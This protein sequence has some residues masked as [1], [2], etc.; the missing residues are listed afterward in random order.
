MVRYWLPVLALYAFFLTACAGSST[1]AATPTV[2][3]ESQAGKGYQLY[4]SYCAACHALQDDVVVVGP[5][6]AHIAERAAERVE[7]LAAEDY[8]RDSIVRPN[9]FIV[10]GYASGTM[11]QDFGTELT[12]EEVDQLI[13]FLMTQK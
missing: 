1:P 13:A 10:E 8:I 7:G 2:D 5:T 11:R 9:D 6:L 4:Q 3:P 12:S